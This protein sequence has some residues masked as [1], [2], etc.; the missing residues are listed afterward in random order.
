MLED[1]VENG[2]VIV[3]GRR[4]IRDAALNELVPK[5]RGSIGERGGS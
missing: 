3:G 1:M 4:D 2:V 5:V